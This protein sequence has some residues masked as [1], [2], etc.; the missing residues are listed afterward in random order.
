MVWA[1]FAYQ[2]GLVL[3]LL[4]V[5]LAIFARGLQILRDRALTVA[6][7]ASIMCFIGWFIV[8]AQSPQLLVVQVP[9]MFFDFPALYK[10]LLRWLLR[11]WPVISIGLVIGSVWL[12]MR[13]IRD[14]RD[15]ASLFA[16]GALYIPAIFASLFE[17]DFVSVYTLHLYPVIAV[18]FAA[19]AWKVGTLVSDYISQRKSVSKRLAFLVA[20]PLLLLSS[21][22]NPVA[23]WRVGD[24]TYQSEK[25][26]VRNA[27]NFRFYSDFHQDI[28]GP[29]LFVKEHMEERDKVAV[30]GPNYV[31]QLVHFYVGYV[32]FA[33]TSEEK[34]E[35]W[36]LVKEG[37][38]IHYTSNSEFITDVSELEKLIRNNR[39]KLWLIGDRRILN[40]NNPMNSNEEMKEALRRLS[41]DPDYVG[42]DGITFVLKI[43]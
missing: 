12:F 9:L 14:R 10:Y 1:A 27:I 42:R 34:A 37:N 6:L 7:G 4:V 41:Q 8:L 18:I 22:V 16:L 28:E 40:E 26:P 24:R 29:G 36:G 15:V 11:G 2:F 35:R 25:P 19:V 30:V 43:D 39:G 17:S 32:N 13:F 20:V 3:I 31:V 21:D 33:L 23:A 5:Y 38:L